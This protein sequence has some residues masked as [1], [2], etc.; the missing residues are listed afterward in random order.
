MADVT[1]GPGEAASVAD[2]L[3][4]IASDHGAAALRA[5]AGQAVGAVRLAGG[6]AGEALPPLREAGR[7]WRELEVPYEAARVRVL[8]GLAC[9]ALGDEGSAA[10]EL[11]AARQ[12]FEQLGAGPELA[13]VQR[14]TGTAR[15]L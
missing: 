10:L 5:M 1:D 3:W 2:E 6:A 13:R 12:L 14:L 11:D 7:L 9:R 8:V 4:G 15:S